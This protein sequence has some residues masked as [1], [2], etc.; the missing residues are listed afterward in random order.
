MIRVLIHESYG[1]KIDDS[2]DFAMLGRLVDQAM[3]PAAFE[4]DYQLIES[5]VATTAG[6]NGPGQNVEGLTVPMGT[7]IQE[8]M[9]WIHKLPEREPPVYLGLPANADK[10]LLVGQARE[11]I[12]NLQQ[13]S[14]LL[15]EGEH[16][17]SAVA[18]EEDV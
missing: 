6:G 15:D 7:G 11:T 4:D 16:L 1:G 9:E 18:K 3:T 13:I 2:E 8:F 12:Q 10:V 5:Q 17:V 14:S